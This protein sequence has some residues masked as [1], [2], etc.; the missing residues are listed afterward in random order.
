MLYNEIK[1]KY[2]HIKQLDNQP[3]QKV[4]KITKTEIIYKIKEKY[5]N[6]KKLST[7]KKDK[8]LDIYNFLF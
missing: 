5:P 6:V 2:L 3:K 8:L 7:F 4:N 1:K